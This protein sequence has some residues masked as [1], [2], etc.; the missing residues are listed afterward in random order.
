MALSLPATLILPAL[1]TLPAAHAQTEEP[2]SAGENDP[3]D[4]GD[5]PSAEPLP[6]TPAQQAEEHYAEGVDAMRAGDYVEA[7]KRLRAAVRLV[8]DSAE[9][10]YMLGSLA[11][12]KKEVLKTWQLFRKAMQL[13][14]DHRKANLAFAQLWFMFDK[15]GMF[16]VGSSREKI[17]S[18]LGAPDRETT[19]GRQRRAYFD[20]MV[21]SFVDGRLFSV[22]DTR[23]LSPPALRAVDTFDLE[24]DTKKWTVASRQINARSARVAYVPVRETT[25][26]WT[27]RI[28]SQ[29]LLGLA[30]K[31]ISLSSIADRLHAQVL[32]QYPSAK[33]TL[34][35]QSRDDLV[36]EWRITSSKETPPQH[37]LCRSP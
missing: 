7:G 15:M 9:Y 30:A 22:I 17:R 2:E 12:K 8:P 32:E 34:I 33:W 11:M 3:D 16:D 18:T 31:N 6:L 5:Q 27:E 28:E 4:N 14:P 35:D 24:I 37:E 20:F 1:L 13:D 26:N 19:H 23:D 25:R 29:R 21:L 36:Y 10:H